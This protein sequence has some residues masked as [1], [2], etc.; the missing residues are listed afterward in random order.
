MSMLTTLALAV[1]A[2]PAVPPGTDAAA[3]FAQAEATIKAGRMGEHLRQD[4]LDQALALLRRAAQAGDLDA[5]FRLG[6]MV[7]A[8]L[9]QAGAPQPAQQAAY[10]EALSWLGTAQRRGHVRARTYLPEPISA[11]L[12]GAPPPKPDPEAPFQDLPA[13]WFEAAA[14]QS[15]RWHGCWPC[16]PRDAAGITL[17]AGRQSELHLTKGPSG[18]T[19]ADRPV[20]FDGAQPT[21][22]P[23]GARVVGSAQLESQ[24]VRVRVTSMR[25]APGATRPARRTAPASP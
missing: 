9:Y 14:K 18:Y 10:V 4:A 15:A 6:S 5:Q 11:R 13:P 17:C 8:N 16:M 21:T 24:A 25:C 1:G 2:C 7:V 22:C 23:A 20:R 12:R 19:F 3:L